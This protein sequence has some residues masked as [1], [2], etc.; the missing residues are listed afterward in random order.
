MLT[1]WR[2]STK[3]SSLSTTSS[4]ML[5][6]SKTSKTILMTLISTEKTKKD[7]FKMGRLYGLGMCMNVRWRSWRMK[8]MQ[9]SYSLHSPNLRNGVR[10]RNELIVFTS[11]LSILYLKVV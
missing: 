1:H 4:Q 7:R 11:F 10:K 5:I 3:A 9:S 8:K 2:S 6:S